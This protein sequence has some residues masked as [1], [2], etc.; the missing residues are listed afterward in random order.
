MDG[1]SIR[2]LLGLGAIFGCLLGCTESDAP[3][4][5][6]GS[7]RDSA[8]LTIVV[9]AD[10]DGVPRWTVSS[11]P[12]LTIGD[13]PGEDGFGRLAGVVRLE[14]GTIAAADALA[15]TVRRFAPSGRELT[16]AGRQGSGPGEFQAIDRIWS[17]DGRRIGVWDGSLARYTVVGSD[18]LVG[19]T[20][21]LE[22]TTERGRYT[23]IGFLPDGRLLAMSDART[24]TSRDRYRMEIWLLTFDGEGAVAD[25]VTSIPG[26]EMWN[27]VWE[28]G[29]TPLPTPFARSTS[30]GSRGGAIY[31]AANEGYQIDRF[32]AA[33]ALVQRI[34]LDRLPRAPTSANVEDYREAQ[35]VKDQAGQVSKAPSGFWENAAND[36]PFPEFLPS[37]DGFVL[38]DEDRIWVRDYP[39]IGAPSVRYTVFALTDGALLGTV[40]FPSE[41]TPAEIWTGEVL[42][43]WRDE[44]DL[45]HVR[46]YDLVER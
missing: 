35:R 6:T 11:D 18:G 42:G 36:A 25:T 21:S 32:D 45:E 34:R 23:P 5:A 10:A 28:M 19:A 37:Y 7:V 9:N 33:G 29:T 46:L 15:L 20:V 26:L 2:G 39:L 27:W 14:D 4:R 1:G 31:V 8:G 17:I 16:S 12:S 22:S 13:G 24:G 38:D 44:L 3:G 30:V 43:I 40:D 41:F